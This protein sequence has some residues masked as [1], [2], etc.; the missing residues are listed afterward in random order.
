MGRAPGLAPHVGS[1]CCSMPWKASM[2]RRNRSWE[3]MGGEV[4]SKAREVCTA[5]ATRAA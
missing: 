2:A 4:S 3:T 5:S 1:P